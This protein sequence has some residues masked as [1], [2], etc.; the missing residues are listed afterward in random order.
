MDKDNMSRNSLPKDE[1][2]ATLLGL[3]QRYSPSGQEAAAVTWL[4][5]RMHALGYGRAFRD[6]AGNAV[7]V[8]GEGARQIVLLGHID[9]VPGEI[10]LR[11]E[12]GLLYGRGAVDAKGPLA[13]F[14]DAAARLGPLPS[15]QMVVIGAVDEERQSSGARHVAPL[16]QPEFAIIGEP[17]RWDRITLGYKGSAWAQVRTRRAVSHNAG[18]AKSASEAAFERWA[19][20]QDWTA[21]Y[22][23]GRERRFEQVSPTL[24]GLASGGDGFEDWAEL[25]VG[26]RLPLGFEPQDWYD[27]LDQICQGAQVQPEGFPIPAYAAEKNTPLVRAFLSS[28]RSSGARPGFVLK[29]GTADLN[30][31]APTWNCPAVAYGP[32]DSSLDHTPDEHL[33]L[34]EYSQAVD[35]LEGVLRRLGEQTGA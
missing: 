10:P 11:C 34:Q 29:S 4:V 23:Q 15:W 9:T 8:M 1:K 13:A 28:I 21:A 14:V 24:S 7:G 25:R 30:I 17:S 31:V 6:E 12:A 20:I 33:A 27:R 3:V 35:V 16:Y 19:A 32:G 5:A 22:N 18:Q 2:F 26:A